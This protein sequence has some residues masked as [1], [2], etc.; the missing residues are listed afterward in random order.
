MNEDIIKWTREADLPLI[1]WARQADLPLINWAN[2]ARFAALVCA[3]EREAC[4]KVCDDQCDLHKEA[5][6]EARA[7][8]MVQHGDDDQALMALRHHADVSLYNSGIKK[9]AAAIRAR[10]K[11]D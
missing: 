10:G 9:C 7:R 2:L 6:A 11:H 5:N 8:R 3:D 4:A 1:K